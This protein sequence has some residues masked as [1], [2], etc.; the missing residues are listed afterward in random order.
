MSDVVIDI[1]ALT[2]RWRHQR[3]CCLDVPTLR[4]VRGEHTFLH[5]PSGSGKSTLLSLIGGIALPHT[6]RI[7]LLGTSL[8]PGPLNSFVP[9]QIIFFLAVIFAGVF[10]AEIS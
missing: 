7:T 9:Q 10:S 4:V 3:E 8:A 6:G 2:F 1:S 5:G